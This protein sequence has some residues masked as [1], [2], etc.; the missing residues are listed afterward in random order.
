[1]FFLFSRLLSRNTGVTK[2]IFSLH[3]VLNSSSSLRRRRRRSAPSPS[4]PPGNWRKTPWSRSSAWLGIMA[5]GCLFQRGL[6]CPK[7]ASALAMRSYTERTRKEKPLLI[8]A[9]TNKS[10]VWET[11]AATLSPIII[12]RCADT[13]TLLSCLQICKNDMIL[14]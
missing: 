9:R 12:R 5:A 1:M 13:Q 6:V 14:Q 2:C 10:S 3:L 8:A 7:S 11:N 4:L